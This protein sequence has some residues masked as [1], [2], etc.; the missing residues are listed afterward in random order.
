MRVVWN[1]ALRYCIEKYKSG[2]SKPKNAQLQK[3]FITSAR[4]NYDRAWLKDVSNIPL[5][6]SLNDLE[7]AFHRTKKEFEILP[8]RWIVERTFVWLNH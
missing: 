8:K 2:H 5:Q 6:Q 7:K 4:N 3:Q 1:D